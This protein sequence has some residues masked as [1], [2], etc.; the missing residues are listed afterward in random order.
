MPYRIGVCSTG[1]IPA[2]LPEE[3]LGYS[4]DDDIII[5]EPDPDTGGETMA[6]LNEVIAF[7][8][9]SELDVEWNATRKAKY[10]DAASFTV[11]VSDADGVHRE[12]RVEIIPDNPVLPANYHFDF[13]GI[14]SGVIVIT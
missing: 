4:G 12:T 10:G 13:G 14:L 5:Y 7:T 9:V 1:S 3:V 11:Y 6:V 2:P 8:E